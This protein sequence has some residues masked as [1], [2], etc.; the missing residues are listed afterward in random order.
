MTVRHT[1]GA[2]YSKT[3]QNNKFIC[4]GCLTIQNILEYEDSYLSVDTYSKELLK[5]SLWG[6][7]LYEATAPLK[8]FFPCEAKNIRH[9]PMFLI[10][11]QLLNK[12]NFLVMQNISDMGHCSKYFTIVTYDW[13]IMCWHGS[14]HAVGYCRS[15]NILPTKP[16]CKTIN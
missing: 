12:K 11:K 7:I 8:T 6:G 1:L 4:Q 9:G 14:L 2:A 15:Y 5:S 3:T 10:M 13:I 16:E